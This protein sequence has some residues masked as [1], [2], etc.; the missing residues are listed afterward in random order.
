MKPDEVAPIR[1][2]ASAA[3]F[4]IVEEDNAD[5]SSSAPSVSKRLI[6]S[7]DAR[8]MAEAR[9]GPPLPPPPLPPRERAEAEEED[10]VEEALM[11]RGVTSVTRPIC[12]KD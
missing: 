7:T 3:G 12:T 2:S 4:N 1:G 5:F 10:V 8:E 11:P 6:A 9:L